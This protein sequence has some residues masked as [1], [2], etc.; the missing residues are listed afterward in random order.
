M[1]GRGMIP[2]MRAHR[3]GLNPTK[4]VASFDSAS[5]LHAAT[6]AALRGRSFPH[7]GNPG[8]YAA[9]VRLGGQLP[10]PLLRQLYA[11]I[12]GAEGIRPEQLDLVNLGAVAAS[13]ADAYPTR[14]YPAVLLGASNGALSHLAAALQIPWLPNTVLIPVS[15]VGD[16]SRPDLALQFG[17]EHGSRLVE[18]NPDIVLHQM[19]D[20]AQDALMTARMTYFR[21]KWSVLPRAYE[22]FLL[23]RLPPGAPVIVA[24]DR[25]TWPVVRV[26]EQQVF[27]NGGRGGLQP[28]DYLRGPH[29]PVAD[30]RAPEAEWGTAPGFVDSVRA[31]CRDHG[32]TFIRLVY[33]GPQAVAR[34]VAGTI[35]D[36]YADLGRPTERLIV[37]SFILGDPWRTLQ[38]GAVPYWTFFPVRS[39]LT[40]LDDYLEAAEPYR[41]VQLLVFQHG[42]DSPGRARI[43]DWRRVVARHGAD[44]QLVAVDPE[45]DP[46]DIGSLGRY[47]PDLAE[48]P[49]EPTGWSPLDVSQALELLAAHGLTVLVESEAGSGRVSAS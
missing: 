23:D 15:R 42:A 46:H 7:L 34:P 35:R 39:A 4:V 29:S 2:D 3:R 47:G 9:A 10:W 28:S 19:H 20:E 16:P 31:W 45:K 13:F 8:A 25:S 49:D 30:D 11:R 21:V 22:R 43:A 12:G 40:A 26:G 6:V 24:D 33:D 41:D 38:I 37:P 36:W 27:Q 14:R 48:L 5:V 1:P 17:R 32:R 18:A 44:L